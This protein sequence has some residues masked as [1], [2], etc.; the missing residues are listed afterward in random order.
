MMIN[1]LTYISSGLIALGFILYFVLILLN[2]NKITNNDGFNVT[3][4]I[5]NEY[6]SIN[7]IE[8]KSIITTYNIKRNVIKLS[9]KC[10][11]GNSIS[12]IGISLMEAGISVVDNGKNKFISLIKMMISNLKCLYVLPLLAF[13]FNCLSLSILDAKVGIFILLIF[14]ILSYMLINIKS[15]AISWINNKLKIKEKLNVNKF[16]NKILLFD[17]LIFFGELVMIIK[18][19]AIILEFN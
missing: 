7:I 18:F 19:V 10:Y 13:I 4:D 17:K 9:S 11:Y 16:L 15:D 12:D 14:S 8:T 5:L 2:R 3:K 1:I 6:D